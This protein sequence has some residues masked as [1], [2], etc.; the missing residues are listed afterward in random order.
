[1]KKITPKKIRQNSAINKVIANFGHVV[2]TIIIVS[3]VF[4]SIYN[5]H[6]LKNSLPYTNVYNDMYTAPVIYLLLLTLPI[7]VGYIAGYSVTKS[8]KVTD[9][10]ANGVLFAVVGISMYNLANEIVAAMDRFVG[11][12]FP[13]FDPQ[14][15]A[16]ALSAVL[17]LIAIGFLYTKQSKN[18]MSLLSL[19]MYLFIVAGSFIAS[20]IVF[21]TLV[22]FE[23]YFFPNVLVLA[24]I[25]SAIAIFTRM[26]AK[27]GRVE[28]LSLSFLA[29]I[30]C[31][32]AVAPILDYLYIVIGTQN[33]INYNVLFSAMPFIVMAVVFA[34]F[35]FSARKAAL[36]K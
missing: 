3:A 29:V 33:S 9:R 34:L 10:Y 2:F 18:G 20:N 7:I 11:Q 28:I 25:A 27:I 15:I 30:L 5:F 36:Q 4:Q 24:L 13:I 12:A 35:V 16:G 1:M 31:F 32:E 6:Q 26:K 19:P 21:P 23:D 17:S 22:N 14:F 8:K